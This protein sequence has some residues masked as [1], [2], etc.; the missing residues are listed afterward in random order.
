MNLQFVRA[1]FLPVYIKVEDKNA[2]LEALSLADK[3]NDYSELYELIF[4]IIIRAH[5]EL[6]S[7]NL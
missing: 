3:N 4:K 2:Y 1:G 7:E 6:S 5:V